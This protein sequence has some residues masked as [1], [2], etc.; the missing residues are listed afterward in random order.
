VSSANPYTAL[1]RRR[2]IPFAHRRLGSLVEDGPD[3][4]ALAEGGVQWTGQQ[5]VEILVALRE[6]VVQHRN[7]DGLAGDTDAALVPAG[8]SLL[9]GQGGVEPGICYLPA[10]FG[11]TPG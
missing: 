9:R 3:P 10:W 4:L 11:A 2:P 1:Q 6:L 8:S 7:G 5:D